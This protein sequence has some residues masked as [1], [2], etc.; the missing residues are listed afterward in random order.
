MENRAAAAAGAA[1]GQIR[2]VT[3]AKTSDQARIRQGRQRIHLSQSKTPKT[4]VKPTDTSQDVRLAS[5]RC[6]SRDPPHI[7]QLQ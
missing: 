5:H 2:L 7:S 3:L 4:R 6:T 1:V